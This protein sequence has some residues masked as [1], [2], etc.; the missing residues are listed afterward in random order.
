MSMSIVSISF[1]K[2]IWGLWIKS[3]W[4]MHLTLDAA[5]PPSWE[6]EKAHKKWLDSHSFRRNTHLPLHLIFESMCC[7]P[8]VNSILIWAPCL[9]G[10]V[11]LPSHFYTHHQPARNITT[12]TF[13]SVYDWSNSGMCYGQMRTYTWGI[14]LRDITGCFSHVRTFSQVEG[15]RSFPW[16]VM[17]K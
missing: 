5:F 6:T 8:D 9:I 11:V 7:F 12:G 14:N 15:L 4:V 16:Q 10:I 2:E 1:S 13:N 17:G 3:Q